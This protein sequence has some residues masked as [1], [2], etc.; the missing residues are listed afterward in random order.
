V[1]QSRKWLPW[2]LVVALVLMWGTSFIL[3]K[4]GLVAYRPL[5]LASLRIVLAA[6]VLAPF[7]LRGIRLVPRARWGWL[8][9]AGLMG[10]FVPAILFSWAETRLASGLAGI[11]NTLTGLFTLLAGAIFFNQR[12]TRAR[13]AGVLTGMVGTVIL[14]SSGA[15]GLGRVAPGDVPYGL[16]I[17]LAAAMYGLNLNLIR[18]KLTG[19]PP[20]EM[21]ALALV[22]VAVPAL[23][24]LSFTDAVAHTTTTP[25]GWL[26]FGAVA[27]LAAGSTAI[28]LVLYNW[29]IQLRGTVFAT[30]TTYL[31]PVVSLLWG[32]L[33]G[34]R[35]YAGH[36][37]GFAIILAGVT[38][39]S[40]AK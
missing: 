10:N 40:R 37:V 21:A 3:I 35:I 30:I 9:T 13:V 1:L 31:M 39:V 2:V 27:I 16:M 15:G 8:L 38:L 36:Y 29:L 26:S 32:V 24:V 12:L 17:V 19:I 14:L 5:E 7:A 23:T 22:F 11:L 34:E 6:L 20:I 28:G 33:D 4:R 18:Y 25:G